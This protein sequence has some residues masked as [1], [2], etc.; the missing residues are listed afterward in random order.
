MTKQCHAFFSFCLTQIQYTEDLFLYC[1]KMRA[2]RMKNAAKTQKGC[3]GQCFLFW[4]YTMLQSTNMM[5][6]RGISAE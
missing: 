1:H 4:F 5:V 2:R 3:L 6:K